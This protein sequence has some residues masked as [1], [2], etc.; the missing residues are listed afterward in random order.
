M[1]FPN[2]CIFSL[3]VISI[4]NALISDNG[5]FVCCRVISEMQHALDTRLPFYKTEIQVFVKF[6]RPH[7]NGEGNAFEN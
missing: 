6:A 2:L 3:L 4:K 1:I 7:G 5:D